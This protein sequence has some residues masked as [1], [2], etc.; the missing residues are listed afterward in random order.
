[1]LKKGLILFLMITI[2]TMFTSC[3]LDYRYS[4]DEDLH[5][6][7]KLIFKEDE[8]DPSYA[9]YKDKKYMLHTADYLYVDIR[10]SD[11]D[12]MVSWNGNRY[13]G[14]VNEYYSDTAEDPLFFYYRDRTFL[15]ESYDYSKDT[16][17]FGNAELEYDGEKIFFSKHARK[18]AFYSDPPSF[19]FS[20]PIL[21]SL[22]SKQCP[23][24]KACLELVCIEDQWYVSLQDSRDVW[25]PSDEFIEFLSEN[26]LI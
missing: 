25:V 17:V 23:R 3:G 2:L 16:F 11:D 20:N 7:V 10:P 15:L 1:M 19:D 4:L 14:Y 26:K 13:F 18:K 8:F 22:H 5:N 21:L 12:V 6:Q 9:I 24:I